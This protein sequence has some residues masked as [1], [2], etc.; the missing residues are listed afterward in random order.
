MSKKEVVKV[1]PSAHTLYE[2]QGNKFV[3]VSEHMTFD[4]WREGWYLTHITPNVRSIT[5]EV[6]PSYP[7]LLAAVRDME[8]ELC[9]IL[10]NVSEAKPGNKHL[11]PKQ[12]KA[13]EKLKEDFGDEISLYYPARADVARKFMDILYKKAYGKIK[14]EAY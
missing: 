7:D 1:N 4:Y 12:M 5:T 14:N 9:K 11:T 6:R 2:K 8:D 13:W 3:P 10:L